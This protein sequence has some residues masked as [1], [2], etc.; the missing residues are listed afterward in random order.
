MKKFFFTIFGHVSININAS[1]CSVLAFKTSF[2]HCII[3]TTSHCSDG[4]DGVDA[5][6]SSTGTNT[7]S[8]IGGACLPILLA[9]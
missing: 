7:G 9:F 5:N 3:C 6:D 4:P 1:S 2:L 8:N